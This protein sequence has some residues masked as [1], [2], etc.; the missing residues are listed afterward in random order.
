MPSAGDRPLS[1]TTH[2][3]N[4]TED[5]KSTLQ[6]FQFPVTVLLKALPHGRLNGISSFVDRFS[7]M[8]PMRCFRTTSS[9]LCKTD[10]SMRPTNST[11]I[12]F[13]IFAGE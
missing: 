4:W 5:E 13:H 2:L 1:M 10:P 7:L 6:H 12:D 3:Y 9:I 11:S 8:D